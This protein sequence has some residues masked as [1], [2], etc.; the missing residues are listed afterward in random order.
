MLWFVQLLSAGEILS[1]GTPVK[2][3]GDRYW[4]W[5]CL[6]LGCFTEKKESGDQGPNQHLLVLIP[7]FLP[8][9]LLK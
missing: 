4:E 6:L 2:A 8:E 1:R 9:Q 7:F 5:G 3:I